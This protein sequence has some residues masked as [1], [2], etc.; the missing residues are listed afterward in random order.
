VS[1]AFLTPGLA[2]MPQMKF[3]LRRAKRNQPRRSGRDALQP[4]PTDCNGSAA[5]GALAWL[6]PG[7]CC[8]R[9]EPRMR[10]HA[11]GCGGVDDAANGAFRWQDGRSSYGRKLLYTGAR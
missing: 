5:Q 8:G 11:C 1:F 4:S 9:V 7:P 10:L 3:L 6:R 2:W